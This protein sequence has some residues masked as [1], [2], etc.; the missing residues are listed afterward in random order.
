[1]N[2]TLEI[3]N[4]FANRSA[5]GKLER[6]QVI[7]VIYNHGMMPG[8]Q[9]NSIEA[10]V[11]SIIDALCDLEMLDKQPGISKVVPIYQITFRGYQELARHESTVIG[12]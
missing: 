3:L 1:M 8:W 7:D 12:A 2:I 5:E 6:G 10:Q 9:R 4:I 11:R